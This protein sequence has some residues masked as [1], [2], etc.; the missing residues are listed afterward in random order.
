MRRSQAPSLS[1]KPGGFRPVTQVGVP[2]TTSVS[3]N[4]TPATFIGKPATP[5]S[6]ATF[7]SPLSSAG[8]KGGDRSSQQ[9][10]QPSEEQDGPPSY[11]LPSQSQSLS[12]SQSQGSAEASSLSQSGAAGGSQSA[13]L[14]KAPVKATPSVQKPFSAGAFR[15]PML[16]STPQ[17]QSPAEDEEPR[18]FNVVWRTLTNKKHKNWNGDGER[19]FPLSHFLPTCFHRSAFFFLIQQPF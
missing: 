19:T 1:S 9:N 12:Q 14:L 8:A 10:S 18:Y 2:K 3:M 11:S 6:S 13:S 15:S 16:P 7:T 17:E 4:I 5:N